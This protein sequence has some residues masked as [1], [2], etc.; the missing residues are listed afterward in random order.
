MIGHS[1]RRQHFNEN[2][3]IIGKKIELAVKENMNIV[4]C[5]GE[6][7]KDRESER[8]HEVLQA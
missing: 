8:S 5:I 6:S 3:E 7:L 1:E 2:D 4:Y